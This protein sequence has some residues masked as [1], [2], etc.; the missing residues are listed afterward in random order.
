MKRWQ[1]WLLAVVLL[2]A[3]SGIA[4]WQAAR[5]GLVERDWLQQ[6]I[7][8]LPFKSPDDSA[9]KTIYQWQDKNGS[10]H[11]SDQKPNQPRPQR[12]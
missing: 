6:H 9:Q 3:A 12:P 7:G 4:Y 5:M 2:L 11:F 10:W 8:S 1:K